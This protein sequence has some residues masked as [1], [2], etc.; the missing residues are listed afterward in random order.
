MSRVVVL[1]MILILSCGCSGDKVTP[2][3]DYLVEYQIGVDRIEV[4]AS[5]APTEE[6]V[7]ALHGVIGAS[8]SYS[9]DHMEVVDSDSRFELTAIGIHDE[10]P[11][12]VVTYPANEWHGRE[13]VKMPPHVG[14]VRVV[15][16]QPDG[17]CIEEIVEVVP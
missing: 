12:Q 10:T 14:P 17:T 11:G 2:P 1:A 5:I 8:G 3:Q 6:L 16:H 15:F 4:P 9:F 13:F 7:V